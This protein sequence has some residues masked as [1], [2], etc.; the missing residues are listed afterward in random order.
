MMIYSD[1]SYACY[2]HPATAVIR[3]QADAD[4]VRI[5][6]ATTPAPPGYVVEASDAPR[7][8]RPCN[9]PVP[10][11]ATARLRARGDEYFAAVWDVVPAAQAE[12]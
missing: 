8:G 6:L 9:I 5:D 2:A 11:G 1:R 10:E 4:A 12:R 3:T 7:L